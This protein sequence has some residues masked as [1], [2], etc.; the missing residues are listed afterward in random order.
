MDQSSTP[1]AR[2][3]IVVISAAPRIAESALTQ[4]A[5]DFLAKPFDLDDLLTCVARYFPRPQSHIQ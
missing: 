2:D 4:G 5:A 3:P 1:P